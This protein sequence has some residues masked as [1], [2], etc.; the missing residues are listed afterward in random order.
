MRKNK[1]LFIILL[2]TISFCITA[3]QLTP[4]E[5]QELKEQV[6]L[7]EAYYEEK[8]GCDIEIVEYSYDYYTSTFRNYITSEMFFITSEDTII[9]YDTYNDF[10]SDSRQSTKIHNRLKEV[11]IPQLTSYIKN[12][13]YWDYDN[14]Y[15]SCNIEIVGDNY[16]NSFFH[17]YYSDENCVEFFEEEKPSVYFDEPLYIISKD[18]TKYEKI[19]DYI[20]ALFSQYMDI[21][22]LE[23]IF[24]SDDL[25]REGPKYD[26]EGEDGFY[27]S[28]TIMGDS[29]YTVKPNYVKIADGIY[30]TSTDSD[31]SFEAKDF[32]VSELMYFSDAIIAYEKAYAEAKDQ[33]GT[34]SYGRLTPYDFDTQTG[35]AYKIDFSEHFKEKTKDSYSFWYDF[36]IK[37]V[38]SELDEDISSFF[39]FATCEDDYPDFFDGT[40]DDETT[41]FYVYMH[42]SDTTEMYLC[43]GRD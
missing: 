19:K 31:F 28:Y 34:N 15:F 4:E 16:D 2:L 11:L 23:I 20:Y 32:I 22:R 35:Y 17:T 24:L 38:P 3:C 43:L 37:I 25:Y 13:F 5:K 18:S 29:I 42:Y 1:L 21:S 36:C 30:I 41:T 14:D 6:P 10:F 7:A 26:I 12:P 9:L 40:I 33:I 27:V 39:Y 8:Y